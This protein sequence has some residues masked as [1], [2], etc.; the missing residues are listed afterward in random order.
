MEKKKK[1][2]WFKIIII[3]FFVAYIS[4][5]ALNISGYYEGSIRRK[6]EFT[7]E[8]ITQFEN[9]VKNGETID[10]TNYLKDQNKNYTNK[11]SKFGYKLSTGID[12]FLNKGIKSILDILSKLVS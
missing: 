1:T 6:V 12:T 9:D 2:N 10:M 11:V 3:L 4:L 8:Q 5:Y 7:S